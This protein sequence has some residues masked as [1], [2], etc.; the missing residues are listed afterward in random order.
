MGWAWAAYPFD[1]LAGFRVEV[2]LP[3]VEAE[4]EGFDLLDGEGD[5]LFGLAC[6][7]G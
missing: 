6:R 1:W 7:P 5:N 3:A 2:A 4:F